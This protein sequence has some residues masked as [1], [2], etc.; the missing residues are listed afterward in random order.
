VVGY[1]VIEGSCNS[2]K[3]SAFI[4]GLDAPRE[5]VI[6]MDNA[7]FHKSRVVGDAMQRKGYTA[8]YPPP[9]SPQFNPIEIAFSKTKAVYRA[10]CAGLGGGRLGSKEHVVQAVESLTSSD[11]SGFFRHV[12]RTIFQERV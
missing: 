10:T 9:Y 3:Y 12:S 6:L 8:L 7:A 11:L 1:E 5:S 2:A 4:D